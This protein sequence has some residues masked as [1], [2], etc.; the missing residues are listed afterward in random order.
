MD[1]SINHFVRCF[2]WKIEK[3]EIGRDLFLIMIDIMMIF[4]LLSGIEGCSMT[5]GILPSMRQ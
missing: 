4:S 2:K 5:I 3:F 1:I